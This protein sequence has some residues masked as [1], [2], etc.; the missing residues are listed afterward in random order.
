MVHVG[1]DAVEIIR[2]SQWHT[3]NTQKLNRIFSLAEIA[4]CLQDPAFAAQ[5][6]ATRFAAKEAFYKALSPFLKGPLPFLTLCKEIEIINDPLLF[7]P[8]IF[9]NWEKLSIPYY[10]QS[11]CSLTHTKSTVTAIII[12]TNDQKQA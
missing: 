1:I 7:Y 5:R 2:F 10:I 3:Y 6:F 9:C 4:Y 12:L 11:S 8:R